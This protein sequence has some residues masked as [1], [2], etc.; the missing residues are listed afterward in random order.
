MKALF[1]YV[2]VSVR[3]HV[4]CGYNGGQSRVANHLE[5]QFQALGD[6]QHVYREPNSG[7]VQGQQAL[8]TTEPSLQV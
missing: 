5:L 6:S 7:T 1:I 4:T 8:L 3:M 2:Y